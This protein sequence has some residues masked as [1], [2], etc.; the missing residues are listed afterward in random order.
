MNPS[1]S[2]DLDVGASGEAIH[3]KLDL[4]VSCVVKAT[5]AIS[6]FEFLELPKFHDL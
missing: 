6:A 2:E 5:E 1:V 3:G 4:R